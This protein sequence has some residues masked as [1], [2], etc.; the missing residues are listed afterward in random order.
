M[1][2]E[3]QVLF[4]DMITRQ[5]PGQHQVQDRYRMVQGAGRNSKKRHLTQVGHQEHGAGEH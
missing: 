2:Q 4:A 3:G 5:N 1:P